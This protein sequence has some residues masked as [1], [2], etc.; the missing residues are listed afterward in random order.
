MRKHDA[1][2]KEYLWRM[3]LKSRYPMPKMVLFLFIVYL[4]TVGFLFGQMYVIL[5]NDVFPFLK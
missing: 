3:R 1:H 5:V 2:V 4:L